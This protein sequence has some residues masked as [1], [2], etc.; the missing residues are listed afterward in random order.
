MKGSKMKNIIIITLLITIA[1]LT[2]AYGL[3]PSV[4]T[5]PEKE[6]EIQYTEYVPDPEHSPSNEKEQNLQK[7]YAGVYTDADVL[8]K[9]DGITIIK[10][11][12]DPVGTNIGPELKL[13]IIN[14]T[15][16]EYLFQDREFKV[17]GEY[18]TTVFSKYVN[19]GESD[20]STIGILR[21][22]LRNHN[23][24]IINSI[25]F[26]FFLLASD[27]MD[28]PFESNTITIKITD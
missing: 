2:I 3:I 26:Q 5:Q 27:D 25:E 17:N 13:Y 15:N 14:D 11:G 21:G 4:T 24:S 16:S 19:A 23:I 10:R 20:L 22:D 28:N 7:K 18:V 6:Q 9:K 1:L 8:Y 12:F